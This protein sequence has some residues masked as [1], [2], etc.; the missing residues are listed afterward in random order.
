MHSPTL[1]AVHGTQLGVILG[2]AAYMAPEQA[3]G[4]AVD[5]RADIWAFGV[6][7][8][9]MLTGRRLFAGET[10][11]DTLAGVLKTEI[12]FGAL[13]AATPAAIRR[14]LRRCLERNP[15]NRLH[16]IADARIVL[17]ELASG[18]MRRDRRLERALFRDLRERMRWLPW[19]LAGAGVDRRGGDG[20]RPAARLAGRAGADARGSTSRRPSPPRRSIAADSSSCRPTADF[21][22]WWRPAE[23]WVRPLDS[24]GRPPTRRNRGRDLPVLVAR[25]RLDRFFR[26]GRVAEGRARRRPGAEDLRGAGR[27]RRDLVAGRR[28][29]LQRP[30]RKP[31]T[32]AG[33]RPGRPGGGGDAA[34][35][36]TRSTMPTAT[37]SSCPTAGA[38][39]IL[40]LSPAPEHRRGLRRE[41][42][43]RPARA[44]ARGLRPGDLRACRRNGG[45]D[46]SSSGARRR[47]WP[48]R[49]IPG[50][51]R[52]AARRSRWRT[53]SARAP[54]PAPAPSRSRRNGLL[55]FSGDAA[56]E[57]RA[58]LGR[59]FGRAEPAARGRQR[60]AGRDPGTLARSR[61]PTGGVRPRQSSRH[62]S[63][64]ASGR[65]RPLASPS[66]RRRAG[67]FRSGLRTAASSSTRRRIWR[68]L[69]QYE[70]RRRRADR[71]RRRRDAAHREAVAL[72]VGL[73]AGRRLD[74]LRRHRGRSLP[75]AARGRP[76]AGRLPRRSRPAGVRAVLARRAPG[77]LRQRR[78]GAVRGLR[79]DRPAERRALADLDRR[80]LDAALAPRRARA[81]SSGPTTAR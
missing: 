78:A 8:Y 41:T 22:S 77:R 24:V 14:L 76:Q 1:T 21:C 73:V 10:V 5:K 74:S 15:K 28:D 44:G 6:V 18:R 33:Q 81:L 36:P 30:V 4:V 2:T 34:S 19:M 71:C 75:A 29:P 50:A 53:A 60:G 68:D 11:T 62:L 72:P 79:R 56:V 51:G 38:S 3:R 70:I 59:T 35:P 49:S 9:E 55:A 23:L 13:P 16:D 46:T 67:R 26:R 63:P 66:A 40:H 45:A 32:V 65:R 64:V 43:R 12:D 25:Q 20:P 52:R 80:R 39:S 17:E 58:R 69:P 47:C 37:R 57:Q 61:R 48:S 27:P 42:R 7:L 54:T 31:G